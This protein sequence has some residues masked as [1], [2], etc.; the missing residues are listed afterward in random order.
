MRDETRTFWWLV[1]WGLFWSLV[2]LVFGFSLCCK[3]PVSPDIEGALAQ[4]DIRLTA[5]PDPVL[6]YFDNHVYFTAIFKEYDGVKAELQRLWV[7]IYSDDVSPYSRHSR[8]YMCPKTL[9]AK[10]KLELDLDVYAGRSCY[11]VE[12]VARFVDENGFEQDVKKKF[13]VKRGFK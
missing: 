6:Y 12:V 3:S 9:R 7:L 2:T 11:R 8:G 1:K 4:A 5:D 10:G 13:S